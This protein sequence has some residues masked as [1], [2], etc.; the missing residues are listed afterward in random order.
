MKRRLRSRT[1]GLIEV[2]VDEVADDGILD[3]YLNNPQHYHSLGNSSVRILHQT[4]K[5][6]LAK[7]ESWTGVGLPQDEDLDTNAT[8]LRICLQLDRRKLLHIMP[9]MV[10]T[11]WSLVKA[12]E[13]AKATE[14][15]KSRVHVELIDQIGTALKCNEKYHDV[16]DRTDCIKNVLR[17][18]TVPSQQT[19]FCIFLPKCQGEN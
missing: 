2:K 13:Y 17:F 8:L 3:Q 9:L 5:D 14:K 11:S 7:A 10:S 15:T 4:A 16:P 18:W 19:Y 1:G 12:L 6:F